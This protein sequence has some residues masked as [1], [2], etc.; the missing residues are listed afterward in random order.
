MS[1][2]T[3]KSLE[4]TITSKLADMLHSDM[5]VSS[6]EQQAPNPRLSNISIEDFKSENISDLN[7][8][9]GLSEDKGTLL[10][11]KQYK[12]ENHIYS[13]NKEIKE[14]KENNINKEKDNY[15][16]E[17]ISL[18]PDPQIKSKKFNFK[19][20]LSG[21]S[22]EKKA[23][24]AAKMNGEVPMQPKSAIVK[25]TEEFSN[26]INSVNDKKN[27]KKKKNSGEMKVNK[28]NMDKTISDDVPDIFLMQQKK[29]KFVPN[30]AL[31]KLK[32]QTTPIAAEAAKIEKPTPTVTSEKIKKTEE[33]G[34]E[35]EGTDK[36]KENKEAKAVTIV[37]ENPFLRLSSKSQ[38]SDLLKQKLKLKLPP[39]LGNIYI[40]IYIGERRTENE[41]S[42]KLSNLNN[43]DHINQKKE[44]EEIISSSVINLEFNLEEPE[45]K[46]N[47]EKSPERKITTPQKAEDILVEI[48]DPDT[49][50][51]E[52][53]ATIPFPI[54]NI[55][56]LNFELKNIENMKYPFP[57]PPITNNSNNARVCMSTRENNINA[58]NVSTM[59]SCG[60]GFRNAKLY[61]QRELPNSQN[62]SH[63]NTIGDISYTQQ[64][65]SDK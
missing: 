53:K 54:K 13:E 37:E 19:L 63:R 55:P 12:G 31:G 24:D 62:I 35:S 23:T 57:P 11:G 30:L 14:T 47:I 18:L 45:E 28:S 64:Q 20:D 3:S 36:L 15:V 32:K 6:P 21:C 60:R 52:K 26:K 8:H 29:P 25:S 43:I 10:V 2:S 40:Y 48:S 4:S 49:N 7:I 17:F 65:I 33:I 38:M 46:S 9:P 42:S 58:N 41:N 59:R 5:Y 56:K 27:I 50:V 16:P 39:K 1:D 34:E 22:F 61:T 51:N 44:G